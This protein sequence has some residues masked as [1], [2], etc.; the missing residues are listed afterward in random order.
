M[1]QNQL[2]VKVY[3]RSD[4]LIGEII[5]EYSEQ[6]QIPKLRLHYSG[7]L[8]NILKGYLKTNEGLRGKFVPVVEDSATKETLHHIG[9]KFQGE[10]IGDVEKYYVDGYRTLSRHVRAIVIEIPNAV[11]PLILPNFALVHEKSLDLLKR[12]IPLRAGLESLKE[13]SDL[14]RGKKRIPSQRVDVYELSRLFLYPEPQR[15]QLIAIVLHYQ[16]CE[17][18][19]FL[20]ELVKELNA[21]F[22]N[23][24]FELEKF[25]EIE[26]Y[27]MMLVQPTS[28]PLHE[29]VELAEIEHPAPETLSDAKGFVEIEPYRE[30]LEQPAP[31]PLHEAVELAEIEHPAPETL[32][33]AKGFVEIEPYPMM[34]EQP[35]PEPLHK[36]EKLL[37]EML[38]PPELIHEADKTLLRP[39]SPHD[40]PPKEI[41]S[42]DSPYEPAVRRLPV[43]LLRTRE[44]RLSFRDAAK[45]VRSL[46]PWKNPNVDEFNHVGPD[47]RDENNIF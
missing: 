24:K 47:G 17:D 10:A 46:L 12:S 11:E 26:P 42:E 14:P 41:R 33:D 38:E 4:Y 9:A 43:I 15:E 32:S 21:F 34:L 44:S 40:T 6:Y 22:K 20:V 39:E 16:Y 2:I 45:K 19:H 18:E 7:S 36:A 3:D 29:A 25:A 5:F 1:S 30:M 37:P 31:E 27:P 28:E 23:L 8:Y 13:N 35:A